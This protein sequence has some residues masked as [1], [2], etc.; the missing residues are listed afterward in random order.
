MC[1]AATAVLKTPIDCNYCDFADSTIGE[2][3]NPKNGDF[4]EPQEPGLG[5][6]PDMAVIA[7]QPVA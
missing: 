2:Q 3:I 6:D 5:K 4:A 7:L 1:A